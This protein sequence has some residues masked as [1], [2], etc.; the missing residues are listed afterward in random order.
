M[1][2]EHFSTHEDKTTPSAVLQAAKKGV[3]VAALMPAAL[4]GVTGCSSNESAEKPAPATANSEGW[5]SLWSNEDG[6]R[7][8]KRCDDSNLV[9]RDNYVGSI[10]VSPNDPSALVKRQSMPRALPHQ[11]LRQSQ[12][13]CQHTNN[14]IDHQATTLPRIIWLV[15]AR[16][17]L[18]KPHSL[19]K[20]PH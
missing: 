14:L 9:Y 8:S 13:H 20:P 16:Y 2:R 5:T 19:D 1:T 12:R 15:D 3:A 10:A 4:F 6:P 17:V 11:K 7:I 18:S